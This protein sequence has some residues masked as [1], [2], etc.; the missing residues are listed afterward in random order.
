MLP[1]PPRNPAV[2]RGRIYNLNQIHEATSTAGD[3]ISDRTAAIFG[4]WGF[5]VAFAIILVGSLVL[6][7]QPWFNEHRYILTGLFLGVVACVQLPLVLMRQ[8]RAAARERMAAELDFEIN[9]K[10]EYE[11]MGLH[12]RID[13]EI[14][15]LHRKL[16]AIIQ[17]MGID[18]ATLEQPKHIEIPRLRR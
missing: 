7:G 1:M 10:I 6:F 11:L 2:Y 16:D 9:S 3:R 17:K 14:A 12:D 4:S 5:I 15:G 8:N 13:R 18:P